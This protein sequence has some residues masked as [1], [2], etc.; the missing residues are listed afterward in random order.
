[1]KI[2]VN[3]KNIAKTMKKGF[4]AVAMAT[5]LTLMLSGCD[6][7][8]SNNP[9]E[10]DIIDTNSEDDILNGYTKEVEVPGENFKLQV[11]YNCVGLEDRKWTITSDKKLM[12]TINTIGLSEDTKVWVDNIH[13]DTSIIASKNYMNGITQDSMD[14][15]V[16]SSKV[17]GFP[18][19]DTT[20]L[21]SVNGIEGQN[22]TFI[23]GTVYGINGN[24]S[25]SVS[26]HRFLETDYLERGVFANK[27]SSIYGLFIQGPNDKEPRGVDAWDDIYIRVYDTV[28]MQ[29]D[30]GIKYRKYD[31]NGQYEETS[32]E[33]VK[34]KAKAK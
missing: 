2:K 19:S 26:E 29:T 3:Q 9:E 7:E 22:D 17:I 31:E 14:D 16:H 23:Q 11:K 30:E 15:R 6:E 1:M 13:M 33:Q 5:V 27:V 34:Q 4:K 12:L 21:I 10:M 25:G 18:I 32:E 8:L 28:R 20:S 24:S